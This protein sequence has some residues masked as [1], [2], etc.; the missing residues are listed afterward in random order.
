MKACVKVLLFVF[1][2]QGF[3]FA[4]TAQVGVA[5]TTRAVRVAGVV[6]ES[7]S[8]CPIPGIGVLLSGENAP[9]AATSDERGRFEM[10]S[11]PP[12]EYVVRVRDRRPAEQRVQAFRSR[13]EGYGRVRL[14]DADLLD[15][16]IEGRPA[17]RIEGRVLDDA[18]DHPV[19]GALVYPPPMGPDEMAFHGSAR[20]D[21]RGAFVLL[22]AGRGEPV[23]L[24]ATLRGQYERKELEIAAPPDGEHLSGVEIRLTGDGLTAGTRLAGSVLSS[25]GAPAPRAHVHDVWVDPETGRAGGIETVDSDAEGRFEFAHTRPGTHRLQASYRYARWWSNMPGQAVQVDVAPQQ[26]RDDVT[27]TLDESPPKSGA[28]HLAGTVR[29]HNGDPVA[30]VRVAIDR[31]P[32][33][34]GADW[35]EF[36]GETTSATDGSFRIGVRGN[37]MFRVRAMY[38]GAQFDVGSA[39]LPEDDFLVRVDK[40]G[41]ITGR[42]VNATG[43]TLTRFR[44]GVITKRDYGRRRAI[45]FED[46]P[47]QT[48]PDGSFSVEHLVPGS[49]RVAVQAD[50]YAPGVSD[51][52]EVQPGETVENVVVRLGSGEE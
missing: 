3:L 42:V 33:N 38:Q 47:L 2:I 29:D 15:F 9:A 49:Y 22:I 34:P 32:S 43:E 35:H 5:S 51:P 11:V 4:Q 10:P 40:V 30:G 45:R 27:V 25:T 17:L 46:Q 13:M 50:G 52:V 23:R 6:V 26:S 16:R 44:V 48:S 1:L 12:G 19:Q 20:T 36:H 18:T 39:E 24:V 28:G 21:A 41:R 8:G 14:S 37:G 31:P 7:G